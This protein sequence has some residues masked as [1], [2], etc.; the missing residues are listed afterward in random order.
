MLQVIAFNTIAQQREISKALNQ[1]VFIENKGQWDSQAMYLYK[2]QGLD[3]WVTNTGFVCDYYQNNQIESDFATKHGKPKTQSYQRIGQV[4]SIELMNSKPLT[5]VNAKGEQQGQHNYYIGNDQKKWVTGAHSFDALEIKNVYDGVDQKIYFE[6]NE[7]RYDFI[8]KPGVTP[9]IIQMKFTG[10]KSIKINNKGELIYET[11]FGDIKQHDLY[12][13]QMIDGKK[14]QV[15]SAFKLNGNQTIMFEIGDYD[16]TKDL[17]I[18]PIV[19]ASYLGGN[20]IDDV[21][22]IVPDV[23]G[24]LFIAGSSSSINFPLSVGPYQTFQG[25]TDVTLSHINPNLGTGGLI[26]STF[27]GGSNHDVVGGIALDNNGL[28]YLAGYSLSTNF[29][30]LNAYS[31]VNSGSWDAFILKMNPVN[32]ALGSQILYSTYLG[33][34]AEDYA[35][36]LDLLNGQPIISGM[37]YSNNLPVTTNAYDASYNGNRDVLL[38]GINT[39]L[40]GTASLT[41]ASYFGGVE[42]EESFQLKVGPN[43]HIYFTG[44]TASNQTT[45]PLSVSPFSAVFSGLEDAFVAELET[46]IA[47]SILHYSTYYGGLDWEKAF[48]IDLFNGNIYIA[49]GT[50]SDNLPLL[51]P[52]QNPATVFSEYGFYAVI[53]PSNNGA[54]DLVNASYFGGAQIDEI[55]SVKVNDCG[56]M[57]LTGATS[58]STTFPIFNADYPNFSGFYDA[59]LSKLNL[60]LVGAN[61]LLF[62]TFLGGSGSDWLITMKDVGNLVYLSGT[63]S[64]SA[65]PQIIGSPNTPYINVYGGAFDVLMMVYNLPYTISASAAPTTICPGQSTTL[66]ATNGVNYTWDDGVNPVLTGN[67]IVVSPIVTTTYTVTGTN[68]YGCSATST[69][70]VNVFQTFVASIT[71][72]SGSNC[73]QDELIAHPPATVSSSSYTYQWQD[74]GVPGSGNQ[75]TAQQYGNATNA[76]VYTVT[77]TDVTGCSATAT[78]TISAGPQSLNILSSN[79]NGV[80]ANSSTSLQVTSTSIYPPVTYAWQGGTIPTTGATVTITPSVTTTYTVIATDALG[81]IAV[82]TI[83]INVLNS[84]F[85]CSQQAINLAMNPNNIILDNR[86]SN[87]LI[88]ITANSTIWNQ[89]IFI[90][91]TFTVDQSMQWNDCRVYFTENAK[92]MINPGQVLD[93]Q[94]NSE[95]SSP[96][97]CPMWDGIYASGTGAQLITQGNANITTGHN[98]IRDMI[99]GVQISLNAKLTSSLTHYDDNKLS[100]SLI[101]L[102]ANYNGTIE[103]NTFKYQNGLKAPYTGDKP[104]TGINVSGNGN[105]FD[106][107]HNGIYLTYYQPNPFTAPPAMVNMHHN[108][109]TNILGG[110]NLW[111][112]VSPNSTQTLYNDL[113]GCAI[114]GINR[115]QQYV[116]TANI[117]GN[118]MPTNTLTN[119]TNCNKA[120]ILNGFNT[121]IYRNKTL[122]TQAGFLNAQCEGKTISINKNELLGARLG[123]SKVGDEFAFTVNDNELSM[124]DPYPTQAGLYVPLAINS[125]YITAQNTGTTDIFSNYINFSHPDY[126]TGIHLLN[127]SR[128]FIR[129]NQIDF[130]YSGNDPSATTVPNLFGIDLANN[131]GVH[132]FANHVLG[133]NAPNFLNLR[134][135]A[136]IQMHKNKNS[137]VECNNLSNT[138]YGFYVVGDN[139]CNN[140]DRVRHNTMNN[141]FNG[142]L[143]RHLSNEGTLGNIGEDN[144]NVTIYDANNLFQGAM[145]LSKVRR[146]TPCITSTT[147][148]IVTQSA[149]LNSLESTT[150]PFNANCNYKVFNPSVFSSIFECEPDLIEEP[151]FGNIERAEQIAL[152]NSQYIEFEE[153]GRWL[154]ERMVMEW[155]NRD[156]NIRL[157]SPV[158]NAYYLAHQ[159]AALQYL[160]EVDR[161]LSELSDP[162]A[163]QNAA[164]WQQKWNLAQSLNQGMAE[165]N[166]FES[167]EKALN[168]LYL[169]YLAQ[170]MESLSANELLEIES[171]ASKCP[172]LDGQAVFKA[173][174][175]Y[176]MIAGPLT[177]NDLAIC[178]NLGVYKGGINWYEIENSQIGKMQQRSNE[179]IQVYPN[180]TTTE[181]NFKAKS[182]NLSKAMLKVFDVSGRLIQIKVKRQNEEILQIELGEVPAGL[183]HY[184]L[185]LE[186]GNKYSGKLIKE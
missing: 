8:V 115:R 92:I 88:G 106:G 128:D 72:F 31:S 75:P 40:S 183:Y 151:I 27:I 15:K 158:L 94:Q 13:Y 133:L 118:S 70:T 125:T 83:T 146:F 63:T 160:Y 137:L 87:D 18:D 36:S 120:V 25:N 179:D 127:G 123:I 147:D 3:F 109:F 171:L 98:I 177:Y 35:F 19:Y 122:N 78:Y 100:I 166:L 134:Q 62:S 148:K 154:D 44:Y 52:Y 38:A 23:N 150:V 46:N 159:Q 29:P 152:E 111:D 116:V 102:P 169:K 11:R 48:D 96:D 103:K 165:Q 182:T 39:N 91:G 167:N 157:N 185:I 51:N 139:N 74:P 168:V 34:N 162:M 101:D 54:A 172:Y 153:G 143:L 186:D 105:S 57:L 43:N 112:V 175:L 58:S 12:T 90:N 114:L 136:G 84:K 108:V 161:L 26:F 55:R 24:N 81:C 135:A 184:N 16:K 79:L 30:T 32:G 85:C 1:P 7:I 104:Q 5:E 113:R 6:N 68:A 163:L 76:G 119:F 121:T 129:N 174:T 22:E 180:P 124:A 47:N 95:L 140:Y 126:A 89:V 59:F 170:G 82:S 66:T 131:D 117:Y 155:L 28:I 145:S 14:K 17:V 20:F 93:I 77:V 132:V 9:S 64:S 73:L 149:N 60:N 173:R 142:I 156:P 41:Y 99:N 97:D 164:L 2:R 65:I 181:V 53:Q 49:G 107:L 56:E 10:Q 71:S 21:N 61:Q 45:F 50:I 80:C 178:N 176:A 33:G 141:Q 37:T 130:L 42:D 110:I 67:P 138:Q 86:T 4:V 69:V 144:P